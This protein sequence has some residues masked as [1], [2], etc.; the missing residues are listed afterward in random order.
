MIFCEIFDVTAVTCTVR[1]DF[2][3]DLQSFGAKTSCA[4]NAKRLQNFRPKPVEKFLFCVDLANQ[5]NA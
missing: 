4:V 1:V 2:V 5:L 3:A